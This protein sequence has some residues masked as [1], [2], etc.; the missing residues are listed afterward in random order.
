MDMQLQGKR[1]LVTGGS[2]GIGLACAE[3]FAAEGC[4]VV[5]SARDPAALAAAADR[6]RATR[7][8]RVETLAADLS[9]TEE[10]E[11]LHAAFPE[12]DILVNNAGAIPSGR[13]QDI[14]IARWK[15]AWDLKVIGY[16]HMCQLYL[17]AMEARR[18]GAIVNIIGMAGRAPRA[19]Y[20]AGGA[21]NAALIAFTSALG[22]AVQANGVKVVGINPAV[23]KT[24]RMLTQARTNAKLRFGD[25]ERWA[26]TLTNLPFGR[27][28]EAGEIADLAVFLASPRGHYVNGTVV[29]VD[30]GGM[31]RA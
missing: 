19:G 22:A 7:Q 15:E 12:I 25:E 5:L 8:V 3:A 11:R 23:T 2:K 30:G 21:G 29:D 27:P 13:L 1:V 26:E 24:D 20:I 16:V 9:R 4:D 10:R 31:F 17:P 6:L 18:S 28:I 14:P